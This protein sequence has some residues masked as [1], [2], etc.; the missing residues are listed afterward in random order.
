MTTTIKNINRLEQITF[1]PVYDETTFTLIERNQY[2]CLIENDEIVTI[3]CASVMKIVRS[4]RN[5]YPNANITV[6]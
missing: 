1:A 6:R 2:V 3:L 4:I 5:C